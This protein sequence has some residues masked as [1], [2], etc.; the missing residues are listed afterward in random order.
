QTASDVDPASDAQR[1]ALIATTGVPEIACQYFLIALGHPSPELA[2]LNDTW[3]EQFVQH[4][5]AQTNIKSAPRDAMLQEATAEL[6]SLHQRKSYNT[7]PTFT[8][9]QLHQAI[10]RAE[11]AQATA[12][13]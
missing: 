3:L 7:M 13:Q 12:D 9:P 1:H 6:D 4:A 10:F 8:V 5:T 2:K 11:Y